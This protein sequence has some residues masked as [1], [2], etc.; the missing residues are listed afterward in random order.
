[1]EKYLSISY[2]SLIKIIKNRYSGKY[3]ETIYEENTKNENINIIEYDTMLSFNIQNNKVN[4]VHYGNQIQYAIKGNEIFINNE[5]HIESFD[6]LTLNSSL[7]NVK[8]VFG[9]NYKTKNY[10]L[11]KPG[12]TD[13]KDI[14]LIFEKELVGF[15]VG[16]KYYKNHDKIK[17]IYI[18]TNLINTITENATFENNIKINGSLKEYLDISYE[19]L[20]KIVK[21]RYSGE[22]QK[23]IY[24]ENT[25]NERV[26]VLEHDTMLTFD[27]QNNKVYAVSYGNQTSYLEENK[28]FINSEKHIE[29]LNGLTLRSSLNEIKSIFGNNYKVE[30]YLLEQN[31]Y[32]DFKD[33]LFIFEKET[34]NFKIKIKY[35]KNHDKVKGIWIRNN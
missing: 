12:Y 33:E 7:S 16:V 34:D 32:E 2:E 30:N 24:G 28:I 25:E 5:N 4:N 35:Y 14:L 9:N 1:M 19:N 26:E 29:N 11:E 17:E 3:Q 23:T 15:N 27:I 22:Y 20:I 10:L 31:G 18:E 8:N 21:N 6:N 13:F